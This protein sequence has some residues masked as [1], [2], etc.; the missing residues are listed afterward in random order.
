MAKT[1]VQLPSV[2]LISADLRNNKILPVYFLY[3]ADAYSMEAAVLQ[4]ENK[5]SPFISSDFDKEIF[6]GEKNSLAEILDFASAF[7]FG[8]GKKFIIVKEFEKIRDKKNLI[9]YIKSPPGFTVIVFL[10]NGE[11]SNLDAE[12]FASMVERKF[13]FEA[14]NLKGENLIEWLVGSTNAKGKIITQENA[15]LLVEISGEDREILES[16]LEKIFVYLGDKPEVTFDAVKSLS[17]ELKEYSIFDL[18]NAVGRKNKAEA[19]KIA[20]KLLVSGESSTFLI[21]MLTK[22]FTGLSKINELKEKKM[23]D[24]AAARIVGTHPYY[25]RDYLAAR[26]L[27]SDREIYRAVQAL[28][29]ADISVKTTSS[30]EKTVVSILLAEILA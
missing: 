7:P 8:T 6:Y 24:Q 22:Y 21:S 18:Q 15:R 20:Y 29:K 19:F 16:Q 1:K 3:G 23:P 25:Y 30:D 12:P 27:F 11:I 5:I 4:I 9:S 26:Q 28:L 10:N 2:N 17:T 14:K 13:I